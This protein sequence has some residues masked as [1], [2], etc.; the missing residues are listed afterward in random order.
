MEV[1]KKFFES[2]NLL[3]AAIFLLH[4]SLVL[5]LMQKTKIYFQMFSMEMGIYFHFNIFINII[6]GFAAIY[7]LALYFRRALIDNFYSNILWHNK[8]MATGFAVLMLFIGYV[9]AQE[10]L[11]NFLGTFGVYGFFSNYPFRPFRTAAG[12]FPFQYL[13]IPL[14]LVCH[15]TNKNGEHK[16]SALEA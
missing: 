16:P 12:M 6:I 4:L 15:L 8:W 9:A 2:K 11:S 1:L 14:V 13:A 3:I 7:I 5:Q 10:S